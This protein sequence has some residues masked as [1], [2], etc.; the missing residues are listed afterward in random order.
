[1]LTGPAWQSEAANGNRQRYT[2]SDRRG[3]GRAH[4]GERMGG[5]TAWLAGFVASKSPCDRSRDAYLPL[6]HVDGMGTGVNVL[7]QRRLPADLRG[8][9]VLGVGD[10][11]AQGLGGDLAGHRSTDCLCT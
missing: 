2:F 6:C 7:L 3:Y 10:E 4:G 9:R 11:R 8:Q 5:D 1:M